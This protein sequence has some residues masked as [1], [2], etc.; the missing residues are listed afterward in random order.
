[1]QPDDNY[2]CSNP[3]CSY[4]TYIL[5]GTVHYVAPK[6]PRCNSELKEVDKTPLCQDRCRLN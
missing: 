1:M 2:K 4:S 3:E 6:C 5:P